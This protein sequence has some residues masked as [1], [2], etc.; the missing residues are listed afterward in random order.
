M[1]PPLWDTGSDSPKAMSAEPGGKTVVSL[2]NPNKTQHKGEYHQP[3]ENQVDIN[4][5]LKQVQANKR[6]RKGHNSLKDCIEIGL[7]KHGIRILDWN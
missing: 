5:L 4:V 7:D 2:H 1:L 6:D 3:E